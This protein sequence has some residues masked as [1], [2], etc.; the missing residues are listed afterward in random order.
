MLQSGIKRSLKLRDKKVVMRMRDKSV[1]FA[2]RVAWSGLR[3]APEAL[4]AQCPRAAL[5][6]VPSVARAGALHTP[7]RVRQGRR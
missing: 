5:R 1:Q 3:T 2:V 6:R 7:H 4:P